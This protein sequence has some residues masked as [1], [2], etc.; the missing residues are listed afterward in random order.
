[1]KFFARFGAA[2]FVMSAQPANLVAAPEAGAGAVAACGP[3]GG[4][5]DGPFVPTASVA[6]QVFSAV[7]S[8]FRPRLRAPGR[9]RVVVDDKGDHWEVYSVALRRDRT[10]RYVAAQGGGYGMNID[11]C[12][13][14]V[15]RVGGIR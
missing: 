4:V 8:G 10:G 7:L 1:M 2:V 3:S 13:G 14:A 6:R 5:I 11:K 9:T 12:T 15:S